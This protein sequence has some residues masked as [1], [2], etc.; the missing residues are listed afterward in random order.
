M[1][2]IG[3]TEFLPRLESLRGVAALSVVGYHVTAQFT[4][5]YV[6]GMAPVVMFFVLS[7]FV[8]A[9]SLQNNADPAR[10]LRHRV[11]RLFP[12]ASA[13][14]LL[15]ALL[16]YQFGFHVGYP[17][18]F[19]ISNLVLNAIMVRHDVNGVMWSMTVE[20]FATPLILASVWTFKRFG[21]HP[22]VVLT[23][24]LFGLSFLGPYAH[25]LGGYTNLAP[26]YAFVVG[27]LLQMQGRAIAGRLGLTACWVIAVSAIALF[28]FSGSQKQTAPIIAL[29]CLSSAML[30][31]LI[32]FGSP[33]GVFRVLDLPLVR[34][35]GRISYSFY[36]LHLI[37][38]VL[39]IRAVDASGLPA[40][41]AVAVTMTVAIA[42][43]TPM[44]WLCWRYVEKPFIALGKRLDSAAWTQAAADATA[45][46]ELPS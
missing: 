34:F 15:L 20:C 12:A 30:V 23:L 38:L 41:A 22:L 44:A 28:C 14:V 5:T 35:Y 24:V 39:A 33:V 32:A 18:R 4:G 10:F 37:G 25:L 6:T 46:Q 1:I 31:L 2:T 43:T 11:F 42:T 21:A 27:V 9:R 19:D 36:L 40:L 29:E 13:V 16:H 8:L 17:G 3:K 7:G 45:P 26:L